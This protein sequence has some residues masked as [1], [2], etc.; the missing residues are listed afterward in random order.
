MASTVSGRRYVGYTSAGRITSCHTMYPIN[1]CMGSHGR[2]QCRWRVGNGNCC[3]SCCG[4]D[5]RSRC[6]DP[7][8]PCS[9]RPAESPTPA[10]DGGIYSSTLMAEA[11]AW[12]LANQDEQ[13]LRPEV[14]I[15]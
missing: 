5:E 12:V 8:A 15:T 9:V 2:L 3:A 10:A 4:W 14:G 13:A 7:A 11:E 1:T 6:E